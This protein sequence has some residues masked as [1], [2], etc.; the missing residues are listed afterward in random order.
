MESP[1][2][3]KNVSWW[4]NLKRVST[5]IQKIENLL[6]FLFLHQWNRCVAI[7][8]FGINTLSTSASLECRYYKMDKCQF[9][10]SIEIAVYPSLSAESTFAPH[11]C[12]NWT[13]SKC[14]FFDATQSAVF[15]LLLAES[16]LAP[17][18]CKNCSIFI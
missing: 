9:W 4:S 2:I 8:L 6:I 13:I 14:P 18:L 1:K 12:K 3:Y 15:P 5:T 7:I 10:A 17:H 16:T 11:V